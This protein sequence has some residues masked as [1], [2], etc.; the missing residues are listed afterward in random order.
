MRPKVTYYANRISRDSYG[1]IE[2]ENHDSQ[3]VIG[4]RKAVGGPT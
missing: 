4:D 1:L 3:H 2:V